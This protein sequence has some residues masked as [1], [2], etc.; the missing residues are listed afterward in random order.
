VA[1]ARTARF[2]GRVLVMSGRLEA[3]ERHALD[4]L[5][6]THVL[7]KPFTA[8]ALEQAVRTCLAGPALS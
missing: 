6:V 8:E 3:E 4:R 1:R 5:Q 2:G 7:P